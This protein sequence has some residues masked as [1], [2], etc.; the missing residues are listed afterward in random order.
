MVEENRALHEELKRSVV[1]EI[2]HSGV[3]TLP[4]MSPSSLPIP[5][6][7]NATKVAQHLSHFDHEKWRTELVRT[8]I[9]HNL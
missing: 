6:L 1:D 3:G 5:P 9:N 8:I 2:M 4:G 7:V